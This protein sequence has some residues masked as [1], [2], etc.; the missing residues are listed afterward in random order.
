MGAPWHIPNARTAPLVR[1][2]YP[3]SGDTA[4]QETALG[5]ATWRAGDV[6]PLSPFSID[7]QDADPVTLVQTGFTTLHGWNIHNVTAADA[8]LLCYSAAAIGDVTVG[9]T[10]PD[11]I[12]PVG[13]N[14]ILDGGIEDGIAF[15]LGLC[16]ASTTTTNGSTDAAQDVNL[17][18]R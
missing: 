18:Y 12:I 6:R 1:L 10:D 11:Y 7:D 13:A 3:F 15:T 8:F 4:Y 2:N 5:G 14:A 9:T 17:S 16:I